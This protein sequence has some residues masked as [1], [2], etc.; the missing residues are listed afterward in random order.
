MMRALHLGQQTGV[1]AS[2]P[3]VSWGNST[4]MVDLFSASAGMTPLTINASDLRT[5]KLHGQLI[6]QID[7]VYDP[8]LGL[9]FMNEE[10]K[11]NSGFLTPNQFHE[12]AK[13]VGL[14]NIYALTGEDNCAVYETTIIADLLPY[15]G[16]ANDSFNFFSLPN[17]NSHNEVGTEVTSGVQP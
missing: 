3:G 17:H 15:S 8:L 11:T 5:L 14:K 1:D 2:L 7:A 6:D 4:Q 9:Q 10:S 13:A 12:V 16:R